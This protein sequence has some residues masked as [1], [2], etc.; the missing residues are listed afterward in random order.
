MDQE[1][2]LAA[3]L[4]IGNVRVSNCCIT[5]LHFSAAAKFEDSDFEMKHLRDRMVLLMNFGAR[6]LP[7]LAA[8]DQGQR[9][10]DPS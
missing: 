4:H 8:E 6:S 3:L 2:E 10:E 1:E 5:V 7:G 9:M